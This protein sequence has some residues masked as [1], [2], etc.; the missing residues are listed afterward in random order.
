MSAP[1]DGSVRKHTTHNDVMEDSDPEFN[2]KRLLMLGLESDNWF[3]WLGKEV[4][5][6]SEKGKEKFI[7]VCRKCKKVAHKGQTSDAIGV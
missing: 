7:F 4:Q 3:Y 5:I 1:T 2:C 6:S